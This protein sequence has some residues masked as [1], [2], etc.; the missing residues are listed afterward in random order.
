MKL[1]ATVT[2]LLCLSFSNAQITFVK[3]YFIGNSGQ[4]TSCFIKDYDWENTPSSFEYKLNL[5][6]KEV[7]TGAL[8]TVS[9]FGIQNSSKYLRKNVT[10]EH[11]SDQLEL[12]TD[13]RTPIWKEEIHFLKVLTEGDASLYLYTEK[14]QPKFFYQTK[15]T[16][17]TQLIKIV[18]FSDNS[19]TSYQTDNKFRQQLYVNLKSDQL[20]DADFAR[21]A[22]DE[23][24]LLKVFNKFNKTKV[25]SSNQEGQKKGS[26]FAFKFTPSFNKVKM[27]ISDGRSQSEVVHYVNSKVSFKIGVELEYFLPFGKNTWSIFLNPNYEKYSNQAIYPS[28]TY[29]NYGDIVPTSFLINSKYTYIEIP[30]GLRYYAYFNANNSLFINGSANFTV[31]DKST[32]VT[33]VNSKLEG[34]S[35]YYMSLGVGYNLYKK[36]SIEFRFNAPT[37]ILSGYYLPNWS[38]TYGSYGFIVGYKLF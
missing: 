37:E 14:S 15:N 18:Y 35:L 6:D 13:S 27:D 12:L 10:I 28:K 2:L 32:I 8:E 11:S 22:Y 29:D 1:I 31:A 23:K 3:G 25:S 38:A 21:L 17:L 24:S 4:N 16:P 33:G 26:P 5:D 34:N 9:E 36:Y 7:R 30:I 20:V 19:R